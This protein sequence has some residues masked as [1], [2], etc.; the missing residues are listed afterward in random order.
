MP[1]KRDLKSLLSSRIIIIFHVNRGDSPRA[2]T[3]SCME[4]MRVWSPGLSDPNIWEP[5]RGMVVLLHGE[6]E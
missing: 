3:L 1:G 2:G 6:S 5:G 4:K